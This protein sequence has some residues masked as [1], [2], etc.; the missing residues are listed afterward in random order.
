MIVAAAVLALLV[1]LCRQTG[2]SE[3]VSGPTARAYID[4][5]LFEQADITLS[6]MDYGGYPEYAQLHPPFDHFVSVVD[7]L[8]HTGPQAPSYLLPRLQPAPA[9]A[10]A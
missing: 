5:A 8:V 3:Y 1:L 10:H 9:E 7:L 2:A 4:P 6:Y